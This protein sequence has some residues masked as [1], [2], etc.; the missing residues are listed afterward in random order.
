M[1]QPPII[2]V[3][4]VGRRSVRELR[5]PLV[6]LRGMQRCGISDLLDVVAGCLVLPDLIEPDAFHNT[7]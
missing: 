4:L 6:D 1:S 3:E 7:A 2:Y 5:H